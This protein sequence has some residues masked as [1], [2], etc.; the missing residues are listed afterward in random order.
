MSINLDNFQDILNPICSCG[1][2]IETTIHNPLHCPNYLNKRMTLLNN[3]QNVEEN[4][5]DRNYSRLSDILLFGNSSF[6]DAKTQVF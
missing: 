4:I 2:N 6:N 1:E 3:L 5:L